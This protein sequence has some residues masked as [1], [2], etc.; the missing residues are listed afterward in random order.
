MNIWKYSLF[1]ILI[2]GL[3]ISNI[4]ARDFSHQ[5]G[6]PLRIR[7]ADPQQ[8]VVKTAISILDH[9]LRLT[10]GDSVRRVSDDAEVLLQIAPVRTSD[11][12]ARSSQ[13]F[14]LSVDHGQLIVTGT[15][16]HGLAYGIMELCRL[17]GVSPWEWWADVTPRHID[18]LTLAENYLSVQSPSV[19]YRGFFI[20]DEDWGLMPWSS[21][22]YEPEHGKGVIG[23][24]TN[25]RIFELMLRLRANLY[26]P[27]MHECTQPFFLTPGNREVARQYGIYIGGSHCEPMASSTAGE[28][29]RRGVGEYDYVHNQQEV[30]RFW[31]DRIDEVHDQPIV[32][33]LG[34]RGVHDGKMK[35]AGDLADQRATLQ[36]IIND[37]RHLLSEKVNNDLNKIPQVFIPYKEVLDIY[38]SGLSVP[39]DVCLMWCDDNYGYINH[40]PTEI[41]RK[42]PGGNGLYYHISYWGRPHDYL[43]LGTFSPK[44]L[45]HQLSTAYQNGI[46]RMWV[47]NVGDIKPAEYQIELFCD[48]AWNIEHVTETGVQQHLTDFMSREFG[49][50]RGAELA[51]V[52]QSSYDLAFACK[53]EFLG[54]TRTEERDPSYKVVSDMP[55]SEKKIRRRLEQYAYLSRQ[56]L[57]MQPTIPA[58]RQ[59]A[60]FQLVQYPIYAADQMNRK[61]LIGQLARHG[62]GKWTK[63][64]AAFDSIMVL[65]EMYNKGIHN[66]GK[67]QGI[68]DAQPRR[69]PVFMPLPHRTE[70]FPLTQDATVLYRWSSEDL[71]TAMEG[72]NTTISG[73][74]K[75]SSADTMYVEVSMVPTHPLDNKN[76]RYR[77][78]F[79]NQPPQVVSFRTRGRSEEWK[80]NVLRNRSTYTLAVPCHGKRKHTISVT[81]LDPGLLLEEIVVKKSK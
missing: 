69:L 40:F 18:E 81:A 22:N 48:M 66:N 28:W 19:E 80:V 56:I 50:E 33:T 26:W 29:P 41:E 24:K 21:L 12:E 7:Y 5:A 58:D 38:N 30:M 3:S 64:D 60:F 10:M 36:R 14:S 55:W 74:F 4:Q 51:E 20:N 11:L 71:W 34:M 61:M 52:M 15:D 17:L 59:D 57:V 70:H 32:Y 13:T 39:D 79:D 76:L 8:P 46:Q 42:R 43:W 9:D 47:L 65:T 6:S 27:A 62:R 16:A 63:S 49:A 37:Q 35:G 68:M 1:S 72:N 78:A 75:C 54:H 45:F 2:S 31:S 73:S 25:A 23:P 67:W 53:P 44:L 77:I